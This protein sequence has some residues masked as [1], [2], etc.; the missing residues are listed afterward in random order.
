MQYSG[1]KARFTTDDGTQILPCFN[2]HISEF[3][4]A[5]KKHGLTLENIEEYFDEGYHEIPGILA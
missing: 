4:H 2:H 3:I 1:T 5:A